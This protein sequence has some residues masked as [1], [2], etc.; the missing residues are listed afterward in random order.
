[1]ASQMRRSSGANFGRTGA[2][3]RNGRY[4]TNLKTPGS[5]IIHLKFKPNTPQPVIDYAK[6]VAAAM[7]GETPEDNLGQKMAEETAGESKDRRL[8]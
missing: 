7:E 3:Q 8:G 1:M 4:T 6:A 2:A 5:A